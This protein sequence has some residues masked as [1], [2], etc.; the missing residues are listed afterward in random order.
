M[1][2]SNA[3]FFFNFQTSELKFSMQLLN[4]G[5]NVYKIIH[6]HKNFVKKTN[7]FLCSEQEYP[8]KPT[9]PTQVGDYLR[10]FIFQ[11]DNVQRPELDLSNPAQYDVN[12]SRSQAFFILIPSHSDKI[13]AWY[14]EPEEEVEQNHVILYL[15]GVKGTRG[16]SHRVALYN[17]LLRGFQNPHN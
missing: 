8:A 14:L 11:Q 1:F 16:R 6:L 3:F 5:Y 15:H 7:P 17:V 12:T 10:E 2:M 9:Y 13:G 4:I